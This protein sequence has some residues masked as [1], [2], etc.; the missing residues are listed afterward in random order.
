MIDRNGQTPPTRV[1]SISPQPLGEIG[2]TDVKT[3][4]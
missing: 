1:E 2:S 4:F 3:K